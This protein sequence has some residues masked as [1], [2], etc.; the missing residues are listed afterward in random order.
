MAL[1]II[2]VVVAAMAVSAYALPALASPNRDQ[3]RSQDQLMTQDQLRN[4]TMSDEQLQA[5]EQIRAMD[6]S[7]GGCAGTCLMGGDQSGEQIRAQPCV[8]ERLQLRTQ[9]R[10]QARNGT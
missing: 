6:G 8:A 5:R 4:C 3:L 9:S 2:A 1:G 10:F 7:C